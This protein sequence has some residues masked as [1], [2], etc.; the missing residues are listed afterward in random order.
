MQNS[1]DNVANVFGDTL[2]KYLVFS[3]I[4]T[5]FAV[6]IDARQKKAE[7]YM[8]L[9][10]TIFIAYHIVFKS[11]EALYTAGHAGL[12][13]SIIILLFMTTI[14]GAIGIAYGGV[15]YLMQKRIPINKL[16]AE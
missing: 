3:L 7:A 13:G 16:E 14:M 15:Y 2:I 4:F 9:G 1:G 6:F 5:F 8:F 11:S 10:A 12:L